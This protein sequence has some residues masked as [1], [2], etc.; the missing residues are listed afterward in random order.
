M[1]TSADKLRTLREEKGLSQADCAIALG[2]DRST[3]SKYE[4]GGSIKRNVK[5]LASF[6][7]VTTDYLLGMNSLAACALT[8]SLTPRDECDV[9]NPVNMQLTSKYTWLHGL[10][11][12]VLQD[13]P[14]TLA[15]LEAATPY[16]AG[17]VSPAAKDV[18]RSSLRLVADNM[19]SYNARPDVLL[20]GGE[21]V[22]EK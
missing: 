13:E 11:E 2:L 8:R 18:L 17:D 20:R 22:Y 9:Q 6:F 15:V 12:D 21:R 5:K 19:A 4:A 7:N 3:Y 10:I 1:K 16:T 14:H